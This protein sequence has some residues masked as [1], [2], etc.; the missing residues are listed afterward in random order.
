MH[1]GTYNSN[2]MACAAVLATLEQSGADGFYDDLLARGER[3][4][5]GLVAIARDAGVP[6][7][8]TGVG[9]L[10]QVWL[11]SDQ[12][13]TDYRSAQQIVAASPFPVL[14]AEMLRRLVI[15]QPPQ[16][17]LFLISGA[18]SDDDVDRTL[19]LASEAMPEVAAAV[20]AGRVGPSG[21]VR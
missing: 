10:F 5:E 12:R 2:A 8:W 17:G 7:C 11:G 20:A 4:A 13:P 9:S 21:G 6:A 16:E 18:H 19:A 14:H 3:L 1:G 15:L